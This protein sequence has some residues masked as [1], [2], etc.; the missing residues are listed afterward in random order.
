MPQ[1]PDKPGFDLP[2]PSPG[3]PGQIPPATT[4]PGPSPVAAGGTRLRTAMN[5]TTGWVAL[6][7]TVFLLNIISGGHLNSFGIH[8]LDPTFLPAVLSAPFLHAGFAHIMGNT[9]VGVVA[10]F[11][12]GLSG[13]RA[14]FEVTAICIIIGGLGTWLL[15]G[16]GTNHI[17][18]SGVVYGWMSYLVVRGFYNRSPGQIVV[19][20]ILVFSFSGMIH[21]FLPQTGLSWQGHLF[22][23]VGGV[24]AGA[25]ITSD[26]PVRTGPRR[27][28]G[29]P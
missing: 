1:Y 11:L 9:T 13:R 22:G 10:A 29:L 6:I 18:A 8:P 21:G 26:D 20:A 25:T 4:T 2:D 12:I 27:G 7:W 23:A 16:V 15:G 17:G 24:V 5:L 19:G 3:R 28:R 14:F